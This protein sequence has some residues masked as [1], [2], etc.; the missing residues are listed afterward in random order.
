MK[1]ILI[2]SLIASLFLGGCGITQNKRL[3]GHYTS[4]C[5][6][7]GFPEL[8]VN[9]YCDYTFKYKYAHDPEIIL[10]KWEIKTDTLLLF[11]EIFERKTV[12]IGEFSDFIIANS[13]SLDCPYM[14]NGQYTQMDHMDAY[15][16]K[17]HKL[18]RLTKRGHIKNCYLIK[19]SAPANK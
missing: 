9:L 15:L 5:Y 2:V 3:P 12:S 4:S 6:N 10:G 19:Q 18:Y 1:K 8:E 16:V 14:T 13:D 17:G 11:S 7:L